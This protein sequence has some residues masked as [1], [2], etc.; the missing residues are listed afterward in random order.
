MTSKDIKGSRIQIST[1]ELPIGML[2][3]DLQ[4]FG[5]IF[6]VQ[7]YEARTIIQIKNRPTKPA[8][9]AT[10]KNFVSAN[11]SFALGEII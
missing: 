8:T 5:A 11:N 4:S 10:V 3:L 6:A 7:K 9:I 1:V 2:E